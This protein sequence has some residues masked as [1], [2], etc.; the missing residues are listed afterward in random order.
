[1]NFH[2]VCAWATAC[3]SWQ[4]EREEWRPETGEVVEHSA[5]TAGCRATPLRGH[6]EAAEDFRAS[7]GGMEQR[8]AWDATHRASCKLVT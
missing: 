8:D 5:G 6:V 4:A 3:D 2:G 7:E 1:M